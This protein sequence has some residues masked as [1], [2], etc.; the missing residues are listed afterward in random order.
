MWIRFFSKYPYLKRTFYGL[1]TSSASP[2][3]A[4]Q[5]IFNQFKL[6]QGSDSE[7]YLTYKA[8][9][10]LSTDT[11]SGKCGTQFGAQ[12]PILEPRFSCSILFDRQQ[13][14][15]NAL[16]DIAAIFRGMVY[17]ASGYLFSAQDSEKDAIMLFSNANVQNGT[18][19]YTGSASTSR[20]TSVIV[21]YNDAQD[22]YKP[23]AEYAED[24]VAIR[25]FGYL[26]K[27]VIALGCTSKAQAHRIAKW[28]LYTNQTETDVLPV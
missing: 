22:Q 23:K 5:W 12:P 11:V 15:Y 25:E 9:D 3:S 1:L 8:G 19:N 6:S 27:E 16:N 24:P 14:A 28:M 10:P 7:F 13:N 26:E 4:E 17:W 20:N 21:R 18:F 2:M